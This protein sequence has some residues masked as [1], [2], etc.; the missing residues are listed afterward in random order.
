M[1]SSYALGPPRQRAAVACDAERWG[2]CLTLLEDARAKD[3][4]G[5][6][7]PEIKRLRVRIRKATNPKP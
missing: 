7:A 5:D 3:P 1:S 2:E 4:A 6:S